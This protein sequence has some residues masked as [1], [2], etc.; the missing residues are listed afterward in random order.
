[1]ILKFLKTSDFTDNTDKIRTENNVSA[2][3]EK[4]DNIWNV[5]WE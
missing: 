4:C 5:E 3:C 2:T 1:M